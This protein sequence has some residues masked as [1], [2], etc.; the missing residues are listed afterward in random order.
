MQRNIQHGLSQECVSTAY[1]HRPMLLTVSVGISKK[2]GN[3][4]VSFV[5]II[6]K[7]QTLHGILA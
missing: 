6:N 4:N 7:I 2:G 5:S 1:K 3:K